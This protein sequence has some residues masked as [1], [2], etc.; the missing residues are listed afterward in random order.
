MFGP[1][2][3][4]RVSHGPPLVKERCWLP[5]APSPSRF[6]WS[7]QEVSSRSDGEGTGVAVEL[8]SRQQP[9]GMP[10]ETV[11][12][13]SRTLQCSVSRRTKCLHVFT[14]RNQMF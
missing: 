2:S 12:E 6:W 7:Q 13:T 8:L 14:E 10:R 4:A 3:R 1:R 5:L 9:P 11:Q